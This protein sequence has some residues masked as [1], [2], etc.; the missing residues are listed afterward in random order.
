MR[1]ALLLAIAT[2]VAD[3]RA[4]DVNDTLT[5]IPGIRVGHYT[6]TERPTGCTV[7]L[8]DDGAVAGIA[9]RGAAPGTRE[10][11]L[12]QSTNAA[13]RVNGVVLSGGSAFGLDAANGAARW[14]DERRQGVATA[15]ARVPIVPAAVL[16]D[17]WVG[18]KPSVRPTADCGYRAAA[19]A[20]TR[21]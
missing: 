9:Q 8:V 5:S 11:D 14:L 3:A 21:P 17:L 18:G 1:L 19:N 12:L 7:I 4:A 15:G 16:I 6:L 2:T 10:T 20:S 13:A